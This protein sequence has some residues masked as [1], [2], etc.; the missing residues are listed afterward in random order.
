MKTRTLMLWGMPALLVAL[1][2]VDF[3]L[4]RDYE[5]DRLAGWT[6]VDPPPLPPGCRRASIV[7]IGF[8]KDDRL[9]V[10]DNCNGLSI[11]DGEGWESYGPGTD[12]LTFFSGALDDRGRIWLLARQ[13]VYLFD[14]GQWRSFTSDNLRMPQSLLSG[15]SFDSTGRAWIGAAGP[16]PSDSA[17]VFVFDGESWT[18]YTPEN[19]GLAHGY[20]CGI[21]FD[22]QGRAWMQTWDAGLSVFDGRRWIN[23]PGRGS[24]V[25][26]LCLNDEAM[27]ID[28]EGQVWIG[29]DGLSVFDGS[30]WTPYRRDKVYI[31]E[32]GPR[33]WV[34]YE[35]AYAPRQISETI[36][37]IAFDSLGRAW[38]GASPGLNVFDGSSWTTY[39]NDKF[40]LPPFSEVS[41]IAIDGRGVIWSSFSNP[42]SLIA[43]DPALATVPS[44]ATV[45]L[46]H[47][48]WSDRIR[49]IPL[50]LLA[51]LWLSALLKVPLGVP[52][53]LLALSVLWAL[54]NRGW[55]GGG[56]DNVVGLFL[57]PVLPTFG[58]FIVAIPVQL[59]QVLRARAA[60]TPAR[61]TGK[62]AVVGAIIGLL[63]FALLWLLGRMLGA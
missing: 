3:G 28:Q 14:E 40:G 63:M 39:A 2:L 45:L 31:Y 42:S 43:L 5:Q 13:G 35:R 33:A 10:V 22:G 62:P 1:L 6:S 25:P 53:G 11:Y 60:G 47:L 57:L 7:D 16:D 23:Y 51:L 26:T 12:D 58:A 37:A 46:K 27:A 48:L 55:A 9:W 56:A 21:A 20:V 36:R 15:V 24:Q 61:G 41:T 19:S 34:S 59:V 44:P 32:Y 38:I 49:W 50:S 52:S 18:N 8:G 30:V 4:E 29:G 17:G 54:G